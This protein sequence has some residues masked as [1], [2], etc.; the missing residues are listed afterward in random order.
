M[1]KKWIILIVFT[2]MSVPF[3]QPSF[4]LGEPRETE[5]RTDTNFAQKDFQGSF[6]L[7]G[8]PDSQFDE[9]SGKSGAIGL[10]INL[11]VPLKIE[12][13]CSGQDESDPAD[14]SGLFSKWEEK[15]DSW[16][17][18]IRFAFIHFKPQQFAKSLGSVFGRKENQNVSFFL[19]FPGF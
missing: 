8:T 17:I 15:N 19:S 18:G 12:S 14:E 13:S 3:V 5:S 1:R 4:V 6:N 9:R 10:P 7:K 16:M 2:M 11:P